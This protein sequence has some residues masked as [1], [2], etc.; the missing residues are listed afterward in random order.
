MDIGQRGSKDSIAV[1][2]SLPPASRQRP[3]I[4]GTVPSNC[5]GGWPSRAENW[6]SKASVLCCSPLES[7]V[8]DFLPVESPSIK[9]DVA[10]VS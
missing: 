6:T 10:C 1:R 4:F 5:I 8:E 7:Y 9:A 3:S 2:Q